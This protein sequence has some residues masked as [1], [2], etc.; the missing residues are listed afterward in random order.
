MLIMLIMTIWVDA[1]GG[2]LILLKAT[3]FGFVF[4]ENFLFLLCFAFLNFGLFNF[5]RNEFQI[6]L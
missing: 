2:C 5:A 1:I 6:T 3:F 4:M